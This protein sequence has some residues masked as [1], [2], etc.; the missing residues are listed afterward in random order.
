MMIR[1]NFTFH[2]PFGGLRPAQDAVEAARQR[3]AAVCL[4]VVDDDG[5]GGSKKQQQQQQ[6]ASSCG[7]PDDD[8]HHMLAVEGGTL[9]LRAALALAAAADP[10]LAPSC[11]DS[12]CS[13]ISSVPRAPKSR[14]PLISKR[15]MQRLADRIDPM[16]EAAQLGIASAAAAEADGSSMVKSAALSHM[17][18]LIAPP[19]GR[20]GDGDILGMPVPLDAPLL[21]GRATAQL[22]RS[23]CVGH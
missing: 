12:S 23:S 7:V 17:Q 19:D 13:S 22:V 8:A 4:P 14:Q 20:R 16:T 9:P 21:K 3:L 11:A 6:P 2:F 5:D 10:A 1:Y 18:A 15:A